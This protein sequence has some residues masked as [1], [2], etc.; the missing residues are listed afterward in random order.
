MKGNPLISIIIPVY[1]VEGYVDY[2]IKSVIN[3]TY[4]DLEIILIDDGSKDN[5]GKI[6][7][8]WN[9]KDQ[10]IIVIHKKN[11]GLSDARN[12]GIEIATGKYITFIDS[13][14]YILPNYIQ[15]LYNLITLYN[16]DISVCQFLNVDEH[17][18]VKKEMNDVAEYVVK[19]NEA[20]MREYLTGT[21]IDTVAWRKLYKTE[22]FNSGI[23]YPVG[24]YHE[25]VWT[26]Y[27]IIAECD[28]IA[29]GDQALYAYRNRSGSIINSEFSP[30]HLDSIYGF[31][32]RQDYMVNNF[33]GLVDVSSVGIIYAS[34]I[35]IM[36]IAKSDLKDLGSYI[37][38]IQ[39]L[40][41]RYLK[42]FL[43]SDVK[44]ISKI[45]ATLASINLRSIIRLLH[46]Y[47][48]FVNKVK[49]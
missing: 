12:T 26:T 9:L 32:N 2:C 6:C 47:N 28:I 18:I 5:S 3:Q 39:S 43:R 21:T 44:L 1:N 36:R 4:K 33:P 11:G 24:K 40:Y 13:D 46:Y 35:C 37:E 16:A 23:R 45:F 7:D 10:R 22:L 8:E 14:D 15:Y 42:A 30:K 34:N 19:G 31:I 17:N 29:I 25:D 41:R 38:L 49:R 20:C 27:R 48:K